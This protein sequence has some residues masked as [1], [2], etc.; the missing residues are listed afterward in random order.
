M[1][2]H[3]LVLFFLRPR[4][5][6][7][8]A[9]LLREGSYCPG[10]GSSTLDSQT[11]NNP[12]PPHPRRHNQ[13]EVG[14]RGSVTGKLDQSPS[15]QYDDTLWGNPNLVLSDW[16][17]LFASGLFGK[18]WSTTLFN[19]FT[20]RLVH[21]FI[22]IIQ[23]YLYSSEMGQCFFFMMVWTMFLYSFIVTNTCCKNNE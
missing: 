1:T 4:Q 3:P 14:R 18:L 19:T 2:Q 16:Y 9:Y 8:L 23:A 5:I 11:R 7:H 22:C 20:A 21:Y 12:P 15:D 17:D 6:G 10:Q 13:G